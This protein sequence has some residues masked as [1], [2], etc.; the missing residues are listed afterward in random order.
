MTQTFAL[1]PN[2]ASKSQG[3]SATGAGTNLDDLIDDTESTTWD[4]TGAT[5]V[6]V[7]ASRR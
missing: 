2:V 3:A 1:T 6:N 7:D 5:G 4:V